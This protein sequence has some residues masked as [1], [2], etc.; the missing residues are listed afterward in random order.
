[1]I[2][3]CNILNNKRKKSSFFC[4]NI[5]YIHII[6]FVFILYFHIIPTKKGDYFTFSINLNFAQKKEMALLSF[7]KQEKMYGETNFYK[8]S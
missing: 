4:S 2:A 7:Q 8:E 1:M 3:N 5:I 6:P